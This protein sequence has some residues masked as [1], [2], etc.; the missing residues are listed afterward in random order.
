MYLSKEQGCSCLCNCLGHITSHLHIVGLDHA[1]R[2]AL[3]AYKLLHHGKLE[4]RHVWQSSN[5]GRGGW[6]T[7]RRSDCNLA[8][9]A[10]LEGSG[11]AFFMNAC[12]S[13][14]NKHLPV[15]AVC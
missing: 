10:R 13:A 2:K 8:G 5:G 3:V 1:C 6:G 7:R 12:L 11:T 15:S 9:S 14:P 4:F